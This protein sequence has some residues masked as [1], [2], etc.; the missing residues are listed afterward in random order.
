MRMSVQDTARLLVLAA[1]WGGSFI[2]IRVAAPSFGPVWMVEARVLVAGIALLLVARV[3]SARLGLRRWWGRYFVMGAIGSAIPFLL[4][5][6]AELRITASMAAILNSTSPLFAAMVASVWLREPLTRAKGIGAIVALSGVVILVGLDPVEWSV[7][8]ALSV[9]ACLLASFCYGLAGA[10]ARKEL[11]GA[12]PL[13]MAAGSQLGA[14]LLLAPALPATMPAAPPP[15]AAV[16]CVLALA[17][18]S[19]AIG[20][21]LYFRLVLNVG[22]TVALAVT[23]LTPIFGVVWGALF[24]QEA[25]TASQLLGG[26]II[27]IGAVLVTGVLPRPAPPLR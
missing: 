15:T 9:A 10:Y 24:L 4:I 18:L 14:S 12:S 26:A 27:L 20:S 8:F 1:L 11:M 16:L 21:T 13:G 23:F 7:A 5:T 22:P 2:F 3:S 25:I 19:T 17:L 6:S